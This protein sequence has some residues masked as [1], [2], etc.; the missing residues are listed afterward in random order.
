LVTPSDTSR[1]ILI[2]AHFARGEAKE[3][4]GDASVD[5]V[6]KVD[7]AIRDLVIANRILAAEG[8]VD[9]FGHVS[10][11]HPENPARY[12]LS[13]SRSP[14][15]VVADDIIEFDL[16][17]APID[18]GDRAIYAERFIHGC[19]YKA[20]PE[21]MAICHSHAHS[22]IPFTVTDVPVEPIWAMSAAIGHHIPN[23]DIRDEFPNEGNFLVVNDACGQ[24]LTRTL[25]KNSACLLRGHGAVIAMTGVKAMVMASIGLKLNAEMLMQAHTL[26][27][28]CGK[29]T[30]KY[31][32]PAEIDSL[33]SVLLSPFGLERA[34]AY[35]HVQSGYA[36]ASS[37]AQSASNR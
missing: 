14:G 37:E 29:P 27:M 12:L 13:C 6:A 25:G 22:L 10:I 5:R 23:W 24:S 3:A 20:R 21:V 36:S 1:E 32:S 7:E 4:I 33:S 31:L 2:S 28:A 16:E 18:R 15:L 26:A 9:A 34:W 8:V 35:W 11:R 17:S 30:V 19:I